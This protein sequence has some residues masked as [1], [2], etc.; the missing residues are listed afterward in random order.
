[1]AGDGGA[2]QQVERAVLFFA[3]DGGGGGVGDDQQDDRELDEDRA[4]Q[5]AAGV[6]GREGAG[7]IDEIDALQHV[8]VQVQLAGDRELFAEHLGP[9]RFAVERDVGVDVD[10]V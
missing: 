5:K 4:Q 1:A 2:E 7:D 10:A 8:L 3:R 9:G 6:G